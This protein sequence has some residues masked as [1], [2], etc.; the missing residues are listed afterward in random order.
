MENNIPPASSQ[1]TLVATLVFIATI[2]LSLATLQPPYP[3]SDNEQ[4]HL[5]ALKTHVVAL[6]DKRH[7]LGSTANHQRRQLLVEFF[8]RL[9]LEVTVQ[10]TQAIYEHPRRGRRAR[11]AWVEN[12]VALLDVP[13]SDELFAVMSHYD[14]V[15]YGPGAADAASGTAAVME[16]AAALVE[17]ERP[18]RDVLFLLTDGEE[19]GL[20]GA[21]GFFR[22]HPL[23][24]RVQLVL[25]FEARGAAGPAFMFETSDGNGDLVRALRQGNSHTVAN[26]LSYEIYKRMP[27]DT[28]AT[29]AIAQG[30][31]VLNFAFID[32]FPRYHTMMDRPS[33]LDDRSLFHVGSQALAMTQFFAFSKD[34]AAK[35]PNVT[36]FT[37]LG[38]AWV[39]YGEVW[40][41]AFFLLCLGLCFS[42]IVRVLGHGSGARIANG[43]LAML[44]CVVVVAGV[45][46]VVQSF[47]AWRMAAMSWNDGMW[48]SYLYQHKFYLLAYAT[49]SIGLLWWLMDSVLSSK[50]LWFLLPFVSTL[51]VLAGLGG[52]LIPAFLTG[53]VLLGVVYLCRRVAMKPMDVLLGSMM[54]WGLFVCVLV[55]TLPHASYTAVWTLLPVAMLTT[56]RPGWLATT[57]APPAVLACYALLWSPIAYTFYLGLGV[58]QPQL[59]IALILLPLLLVTACRFRGGVVL[60]LLGIILVAAAWLTE[61]FDEVHPRP[62]QLFVGVDADAQQTFLVS[63]DDLSPW[64]ETTLGT[65]R[66]Q[67]SWARFSPNASGPI[68][69]KEIEHQP[70][71]GVVV[72]V[73]SSADATGHRKLVVHIAGESVI[74]NLSLWFP[75][76]A[77]REVS[78]EGEVLPK[79]ENTHTRIRLLGLPPEGAQ[80]TFDLLDSNEKFEIITTEQRVG[81]PSDLPLNPRPK[82]EMLKPYT[83]SDS[84][85]ITKTHHF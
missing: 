49:L 17:G 73:V 29:I 37:L 64:L 39:S 60:V 72:D 46:E 69:L 51:L 4:A 30:K 32:D 54:L 47:M 81:W 38:G 77:V 66:Y 85:V 53:A 36:Y 7:P 24:E 23:A 33:V 12:I 78:I 71:S 25:N 76:Q 65:N 57:W 83:Y 79:S 56:L 74:E 59:V 61:G 26:S 82:T 35:S 48:W 15:A 18:K 19:Q 42:A 10:K 75:S 43:F 58:W 45:G 67:D 1:R 13:D 70:D 21:Q 14:S 9:G 68:N 2:G 55:F 11:V 5:N 84:V 80:L 62:T 63:D 3:K 52:R 50:R 22:T 34:L 41:Y 40:M 16:A 44:L 6:A 31:Q 28:D 8:E 20:M 27:N